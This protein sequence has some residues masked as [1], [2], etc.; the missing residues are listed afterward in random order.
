MGRRIPEEPTYRTSCPPEIKAKITALENAALDCA[1]AGSQHP[2]DADAIRADAQGARYCLE[3]T[4]LT[5]IE[6]AVVEAHQAVRKHAAY[7]V[8]EIEGSLD[9]YEDM[10]CNSLRAQM[11]GAIN[12]AKA[13]FK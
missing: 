7:H 8:N 13:T 11:R 3:Q 10:P 4:I 2:D 9:E 5:A 1:F 12:K 6:K